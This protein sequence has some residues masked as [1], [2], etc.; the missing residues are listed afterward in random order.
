MVDS[1]I[2]ELRR[3]LERDPGSRLFA[4][5]A[6]EHRK[7]GD[8]AEAVR[9]SRAGLAQHP[10]YP[11]AR[12]T[13]GR[14]LLESGD[15]AAA[16]RELEQALR[17]APDNILA[18]RFL[19]Q[20]LEAVGALGEALLQYGAT[21]KMAPGD[22]QLEAQVQALKAR[23]TTAAVPAPRSEP[24]PSPAP[25]VAARPGTPA[26][27]RPAAAARPPE[28]ESE[29]P[30]TVLL[31]GPERPRPPVPEAAAEPAAPPVADL[32]PTIP[33][34]R[35]PVP[36][37]PPPAPAVPDPVIT[38]KPASRLAQPEFGDTEPARHVPAVIAALPSPEPGAEPRAAAP[39]PTAVDAGTGAAPLSSSTLA[40]LYLRQGL[41]EQAVEVYRQVLSE[42]PGN[43]RARAR[44]AEI[45]GPASP[46]PPAAAT[47][48]PRAAR[49]RVLE[50]TIAGLEALLASLQRR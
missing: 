19:G 6:E 27:V 3:R 41:P 50:R 26:A 24:R 21:L 34:G 35:A 33:L 12:L 37:P 4:Q 15:A 42:D 31:K 46:G 10:N 2:D 48:D 20:A 43:E 23:L 32:P 8:H 25:P 7:A 39:E 47:D 11:S 16:R 22:R 5:L 14:A 9:V 17:E 13:L 36:A 18:S 28:A 29:L 44:L 38:L 30:A 40:E 45:A 1:R 49:R